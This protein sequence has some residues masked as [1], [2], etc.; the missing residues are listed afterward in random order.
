M[1]FTVIITDLWNEVHCKWDELSQFE[2]IKQNQ[3]QEPLLYE[4]R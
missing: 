3:Q 1:K 2:Y 4:H